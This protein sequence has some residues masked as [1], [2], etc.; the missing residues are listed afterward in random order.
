M[1][2]VAYLLVFFLLIASFF[3]KEIEPNGEG[4]QVVFSRRH[5]NEFKFINLQN[6]QRK[7]LHVRRTEPRQ[8]YKPKKRFHELQNS[9]RKQNS[10][11]TK[12]P[13]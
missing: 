11:T 13:N 8:P 12:I 5:T 6:F 10:K 1:L 4:K 3:L 9:I 7:M 2:N